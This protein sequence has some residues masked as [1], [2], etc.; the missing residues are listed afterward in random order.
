MLSRFA[1]LAAYIG[2]A[3]ARHLLIA[4]GLLVGLMVSSGAS[5]L[6]FDLRTD[7]LEDAKRDLRN[8]SYVLSL[9]LD[10]SFQ[11]LELVERG[12]IETWQQAGIDTPEELR[13]RTGSEQAHQ[14][15]RDRIAA[16]PQVSAVTLFDAQGDLINASTSWPPPAMSIG[17]REYFPRLAA[18]LPGLGSDSD[19]STM[20]AGPV[21]SRATGKRA[22]LL[23]HRFTGRD[24][25]LLGIVGGSID[26]DY[27]EHLFSRISVA[28]GGSFSLFHRNDGVLLA[29]HPHVEQALGRPLPTVSFARNL[30]A[31]DRDVFSEPGPFDGKQR[32]IAP[33]SVA[34]Y[35]MF[36]SVTTTTEAALAGW[37]G[38]ARS[39]IGA[40]L[41]ADLVLAA[42]VLL[43][44]RHVRSYEKL[45]AAETELAV[46]RE[47][48]R[49]ARELQEHSAHFGTALSHMQQGLCM[50]DGRNRLVVMNNRVRELFNLPD[51]AV[52][53]GMDHL[54]A[55]ACMV[56]TGG[57]TADD[58]QELRE[59]RK[60]TIDR[61]ECATFNWE[62][63]DG[64]TMTV[65][66]QPMQ[67][68]WLTTYENI[69]E[70]RQAEARMA[71]MARHD[72]LTNLP[73]RVLFRE[74]LE[75]ALAHVRRGQ[76]LA[77]LCLDL[78][79]FKA[80]NDTL[81]HPIGDSLL[82]AVAE[83]LAM[84]AR[85]TDT[86]AR[87][88]GDEFAIVQ[89]AIARPTEATALAG[90]LIELLNAPFDVDGHQ[91]VIGTSIGIT[92]APQ[93]GDDPDQLLRCAD[94]ALYRAKVDGRGIYRLFHAEMDAQMQARRL[95]ELDLRKAAQCG[96]LEP[97]YQ[98]L[99]DVHDGAI[100]GFE[101]LL[102]WRHP[103]RGLIPPNE[104]IPLAEEIG[105]IVGIGEWVLW[106]ACSD[107]VG[108][109]GKL[110]VAVNLSPAQ[111][112][113]RNLVAA[114]AHALSSSGLSP[115]RLELEITETA[116][117]QDTEVTLATLQELHGLGV[118]T[119]M[120]DFGTGYS[121]LSYLRRFPFDRIK[122][123]QSFVRE[124][125]TRQDCGAIV[126]AV[127][128][129]SGELGMQTT[130]EGVETPEQYDTL[131]AMGCS[132]VQGYLFSPA[133][134]RN[135]VPHLLDRIPAMFGPG[136]G[137]I[138]APLGVAPA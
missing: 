91:I 5:L 108:W 125:G 49:S 81:G 114:V 126:R 38:Q 56:A 89:T 15:L 52:M 69:T 128:A 113:S 28:S 79:Q 47:R 60:Q 90:R 127:A 2:H 55:T 62:L 101:A 96:E 132:E 135:Q 109:P 98:P 73:N 32:V 115:E 16:L 123:D 84:S 105:L 99:I 136:R 66:H 131:A 94:L 57:V 76:M 31:L 119:A 104:F 130:A 87:L 121:S 35:P 24:G 58:M 134:P 54:E 63:A 97:F 86:V 23:F 20:I 68:G 30:A 42:I 48:E 43:G 14:N 18:E 51:D 27:I 71:H 12:I 129:L 138:G 46:T 21:M 102:R 4:C 41:V 82:R 65:T 6:I 124:L 93:D 103:Q 39:L 17:D 13:A 45:Q 112:K 11:S 116:M 59:W 7:A 25:R 53:T 95:L 122:I 67:D 88:G 9:E 50:F 61:G 83:R 1:R 70:R 29:R 10:Q 117:L 85:E 36:I 64:R 107:A 77:L 26:P 19:T 92:F 75:A 72:A 8:L 37:W 74:K 34:H 120:D 44:V 22:I 3:R 40:T 110:R 80:V 33:H 78:D 137:A 111:F 133:V 106:R 118:R 100:A